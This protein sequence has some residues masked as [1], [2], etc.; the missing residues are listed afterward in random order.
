MQMT[1]C[2]GWSAGLSNCIQAAHRKRSEVWFDVLPQPCI[3]GPYACDIHCTCTGANM[4]ARPE[5]RQTD[6]HITVLPGASNVTQHPQSCFSA[7]ETLTGPL[8][9]LW[10]PAT[11]PPAATPSPGVWNCNGSQVST[12]LARLTDT[13]CSLSFPPLRH[14]PSPPTQPHTPTSASLP[15]TYAHTH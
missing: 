15:P 2:R 12:F 11:P 3:G 6:I 7:Q 13:I 14:P 5:L 1:S 8:Q 10:Y 9:W 4:L